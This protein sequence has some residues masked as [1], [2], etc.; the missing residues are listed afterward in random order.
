MKCNNISKTH[1]PKTIVDGDTALRVLCIEC[2]HQFT[3]RKDP[4]KKVPENREYSKIYKRD[5]L[6]GKDNLFYKYYSQYMTT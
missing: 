5:I 3:L 2:R 4:F 6:Q 1:N